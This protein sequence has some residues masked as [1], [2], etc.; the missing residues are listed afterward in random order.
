MS[1]WKDC[2]KV[3]SVNG[4]DTKLSDVL[5]CNRVQHKIRFQGHLHLYLRNYQDAQTEDAQLL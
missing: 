5:A 3:A 4:D 1:S 2:V